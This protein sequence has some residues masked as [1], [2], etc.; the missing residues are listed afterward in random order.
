VLQK[1]TLLTR[2]RQVSLRQGRIGPHIGSYQYFPASIFSLPFLTSF[3]SSS[4]FFLKVFSLYRGF[5][6][7]KMAGPL[8]L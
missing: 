3:F 4:F 8:S 1:T 6:Y 5:S 7:R 2:N